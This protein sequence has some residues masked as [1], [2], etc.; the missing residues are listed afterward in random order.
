MK[1]IGG[2]NVN[3][4]SSPILTDLFFFYSAVNISNRRLNRGLSILLQRYKD[5]S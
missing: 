4:V 3:N 1:G 2:T 5:S